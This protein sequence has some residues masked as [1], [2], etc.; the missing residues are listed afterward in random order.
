VRV[1]ELKT[2]LDKKFDHLEGRINDLEKS[3]D[4]LTGAWKALTVLSGIGVVCIGFYL[5][6]R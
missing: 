2:H 4:F 1:D 3:R 5:K 6:L